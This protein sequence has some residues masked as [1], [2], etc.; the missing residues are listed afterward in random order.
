MTVTHSCRGHGESALVERSGPPSPTPTRTH[1]AAFQAGL[2]H[3]TSAFTPGGCNNALDPK[4][5]PLPPWWH[6]QRGASIKIVG[7]GP[8]LQGGEGHI[9]PAQGGDVAELVTAEGH[10]LVLAGP[11][12]LPRPLP[13]GFLAG[14]AV[15]LEGL[16][17][18]P[19]PAALV[20][21]EALGT[22]GVELE[23]HVGDLVGFA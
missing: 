23:P 6:L 1:P 15:E 2:Q 10:L 18:P 19:G 9:A 12:V 4:V 17:G 14:G 22:A 16:P 21:G 7:A 3:I 13:V 11:Q 8:S 5:H 20:D